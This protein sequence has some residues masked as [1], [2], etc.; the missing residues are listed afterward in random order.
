MIAGRY[1]GGLAGQRVA[2]GRSGASRGRASP[3]LRGG[4]VATARPRVDRD[5]TTASGVTLTLTAAADGY[6]RSDQPAT[7]FGTAIQLA[8]NGSSTATMISYLRFDVSGLSG[9]PASATLSYFSQS[10]GATKT[11]VHLVTGSWNEDTLTYANKPAYGATI[12]TTGALTAGTRATADVSSVVT[13][14]GS[15]SFALD[16]DGDRHPLGRQSGGSQPAPAAGD[17]EQRHTDAD[18]N[19]DQRDAL[20]HCLGDALGHC[21]G[22]A[23]GHRLGDALGHRDRGAVGRSDRVA[24]GHRDRVRYPDADRYRCLQPQYHRDCQHQPQYHRAEHQPQYHRG[25]QH[26]PQPDDPVTTPTRLPHRRRVPPRRRL[27]PR[28][29]PAQPPAQRGR[30]P[31]PPRPPP[32]IR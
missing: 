3:G 7:N 11:A 29:P 28:R 26:Q 13:G 8:S 30:P 15:Y 24:V 23:V 6:V 5:P 4:G 17:R 32:L 22:G 16:H 12:S 10:T 27:P 1:A 9:P 19:T 20:G 21:L 18:T 2:A 14:N 31:A 25:A